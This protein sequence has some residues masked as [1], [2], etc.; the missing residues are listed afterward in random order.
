[1]HYLI[2]LCNQIGAGPKKLSLQLISELQSHSNLSKKFLIIV[3][4]Y[5]EYKELHSSENVMFIKIK[6]FE[7]VLMKAFSRL[8]FDLFLIPRLVKKYQISSLLAFG[9]FLLSPIN[10]K[11]IVLLHHPYLF[12]D[13]QLSRLGSVKKSIEK[14][15]RVLFS[16]TLRNTDEVV[17]ETHYVNKQLSHKW[18]WFKGKVHI[19]E[20]PISWSF[21]SLDQARLKTIIDNRASSLHKSIQIIFVSRFYPHKNHIFL[22]H[23]SALLQQHSIQHIIKVTVDSSIPETKI[24]LKMIHD[25]K[26]PIINLGEIDQKQLSGEYEQAHL[27]IFPS[28]SETFGIPLIEALNFALPVMTPDLDYAKAI[29]GNAGIYFNRGS[30]EECLVKLHRLVNNKQNYIDACHGSHKQAKRF[31]RSDQ[32][33]EDYLKIL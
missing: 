27:M 28:E 13:D 5:M 14:L 23:L 20:N 30:T 21:A 19:I 29:L 11:K 10:I 4:D 22:C 25:Q 9:N 26:L 6:R 12:D 2:N 16:L 32:W 15:K 31:K 3:P 24:F 33:L 1:M 18:P 17:V 7:S 8:Y